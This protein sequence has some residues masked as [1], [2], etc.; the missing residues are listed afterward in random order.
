MTSIYIGILLHQK[1]ESV[2]TF[3]FRAHTISSNKELL[4]KEVKHLKH[5]FITINGFPPW[6]VWQVIS[7]VK[8]KFLLFR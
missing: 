6:V 8:K 1:R 7:C 2:K 3:L 5:V 4:D